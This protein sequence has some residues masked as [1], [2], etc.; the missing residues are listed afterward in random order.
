MSDQVILCS[1]SSGVKRNEEMVYQKQSCEN[2]ELC[3][4]VNQAV[5]SINWTGGEGGGGGQNGL[6]EGFC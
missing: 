2:W 5:L 6:P 1:W 4:L 3:S